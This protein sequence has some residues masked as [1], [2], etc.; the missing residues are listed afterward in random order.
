ERVWRDALTAVPARSAPRT[1][2]RSQDARRAR[3][4]RFHSRGT[5]W[6][7]A[8]ATGGDRSAPG[9]ADRA[10]P[11][12]AAAG[13]DALVPASDREDARRLRLQ[14]PALGQARAAREPA[15]PG[16]PRAEGECRLPLAARRGEN[17]S[18]D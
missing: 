1:A 15:H 10:P 17:T 18:R 4:A 14:L 5:R 7:R 9:R 2:G 11:Q 8:P 6:R 13:G 16:L 3:S 12:R